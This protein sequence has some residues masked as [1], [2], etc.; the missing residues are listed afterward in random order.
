VNIPNE[1]S[2][3]HKNTQ[4][5]IF[6]QQTSTHSMIMI[7]LFFSLV[8]Q[9]STTVTCA[10]IVSSTSTSSTVISSPTFLPSPI[11][12]KKAESETRVKY[13]LGLGKNLPVKGSQQAFQPHHN[14][15]HAAK[16]WMVSDSTH[17]FPQPSS[18][19]E[20][21]TSESAISMSTAKKLRP[22]IP[23]RFS[24]DA[25]HISHSEHE[26][27]AVWTLH[28]NE[29]DINTMWVE[30]LIHHEQMIHATA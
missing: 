8:M 6:I 15:Q 14:V 2:L 30:M 26:A 28:P 7:S 13:D 12:T 24:D 29:V 20:R 10:Y 5:N 21:N 4:E 1:E 25:I 27:Q 18:Q 11:T 22:I 9:A 23:S 17:S 19:H 3:D 16:Y